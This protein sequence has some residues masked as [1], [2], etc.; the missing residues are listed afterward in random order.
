LASRRRAVT[1]SLAVFSMSVIAGMVGRSSREAFAA[2]AGIADFPKLDA[3]RIRPWWRAI[4]Q[5]LESAASAD[6]PVTWSERAGVAWRTPSRA[7]SHPRP[8]SLARSS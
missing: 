7:A 3:D 2:D 6:A 1:L 8:S 4:A 5:W